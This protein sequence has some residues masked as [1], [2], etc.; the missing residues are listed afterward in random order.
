VSGATTSAPPITDFAYVDTAI[1]GPAN[2]NRVMRLEDFSPPP[3]ARDVYAT[4][5]RYTRELPDYA[6][7][8]PI[9][10]AKDR[11]S[12]KGFRG[13]AF[14]PFLPADFDCAHDLNRAREDAIRAVTTLEARYDVPPSAVRL[15]FSGTKGFSLEI[16]GGLFAGFSPAVDLPPR[17]KRLADELFADCPTLDTKIYESVRLWR[18]VNSRHGKSGLYKVRLTL[19]E[20]NDL[21]IEEIRCLAATPRPYQDAAD[22]DWFPRAGLVELWANTTVPENGHRRDAAEHGAAVGSR[23]L[24]PEQE[25]DLIKLMARNWFQ[26]QK[27]NIALGL[28]GWL[29][30]AGVPEDQAERLFR[31]LSADDKRPDD[32]LNCL[33]DSYARRRSSQPITGPSRLREYLPRDDMDALERILPTRATMPRL[34]LDDFVAHLATHKYLYRPTGD[35]WPQAGVNAAVDPASQGR[36]DANGNPVYQLA[37]N[38]IDEHE[39]VHQITWSPRDPEIIAGRLLTQG[40]WIERSDFRGYNQYRPP[41]ISL[42]GPEQAGRW[43]EHVRL[44]YPEQADHIIPWL[45]HRVQHPEEK[46]NHALL[47]GG[48]QGCGKD[49]ILKPVREAIGPWNYADASPTQVMGRFN[50]FLKSVILLVPEL[51]D[52][53]DVNRYTFYEHMK[54]IIAAPPTTLRCDE[55]FQQETQ[56]LNV[57]GVIFTSNQRIGIYLPAGDRRHFAAWSELDPATLPDRYFTALHHWLD[58]DQGNEHVAAYLHAVDL[59]GFDP[60]APPPKTE[61][62][63]SI[64]DAGRAPEESELATLLDAMSLCPGEGEWPDAV[65]LAQ[66]VTAE[67]QRSGEWNSDER[68]KNGLASWLED[69]KN[70]RQIP[71]RMEAVGYVAVRNDGAK[72]GLWK[73]GGARMAVYAKRELERRDQLSAVKRLLSGAGERQ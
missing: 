60:N 14:A 17:F 22:D 10:A 45:A 53:G 36:I 7:S 61:W 25:R 35:L 54:P 28:A 31:R 39:P 55:K 12:V 21:S 30:I 19:G 9:V 50:G 40:G 65:T 24:T 71:H 51:C 67:K 6:N 70:R 27:H 49:T 1:G 13:Q 2:R 16:P 69:R 37:S 29:A 64:V 73:V 52:L 42:G 5:F 3:D 68:D 33:R 34:R 62:F 26:S 59:T 44:L 15:A 72:D 18:V 4:Y 23:L 47:L 57:T 48:V 66:L 8:N 38:W 32:R 56:V 20:L 63:W 41:A 58:Q 43:V 46:V 11:P